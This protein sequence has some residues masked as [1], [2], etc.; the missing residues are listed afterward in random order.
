MDSSFA[1]D[2]KANGAAAISS[3]TRESLVWGTTLSPSPMLAEHPNQPPSTPNPTTSPHRVMDSK[4]QI[5]DKAGLFVPSCTRSI[6]CNCV[7]CTS[8]LAIVTAYHIRRP[9]DLKPHT[10]TDSHA[11]GYSYVPS[12]APSFDQCHRNSS[13]KD[14]PCCSFRP[15]DQR[16]SDSRLYAM[17]IAM[18]SADSTSL[19]K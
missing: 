10:S 1:M 5:S 16:S 17:D 3:S 2:I 6:H 7:S 13:L 14:P 19:A 15:Y 12:I 9:K 18:R 8:S 4:K 11:N